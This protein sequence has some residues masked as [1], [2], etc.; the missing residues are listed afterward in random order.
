MVSYLSCPAVSLHSKIIINN[1]NNNDNNN[2]N[3]NSCDKCY[4]R[5]IQKDCQTR[6]NLFTATCFCK[7]MK[8]Q[9]T[10]PLESTHLGCIAGVLTK[11]GG[12]GRGERGEKRGKSFPPSPPRPTFVR[13]P[14]MQAGILTESFHL[15]GHTFRFRWKDQDLEVFLV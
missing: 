4:N 8:Q 7:N 6:F 5:Y 1:N 12:R 10:P 2:N 15:S 9:L 11:V 14:A 13:M 3:N